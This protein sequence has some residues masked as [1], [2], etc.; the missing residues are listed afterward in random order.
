MKQPVPTIKDVAELTGLSVC[1]VSHAIHGTRHVKP[2]T[3][4]RVLAV[5]EQ[6]GYRP[7]RLARGL[8]T[9]RTNTVGCL[10]SHV[11]VPSVG[12]LVTGAE[13]V[14]VAHGYSP[15]LSCTHLQSSFELNAIRTLTDLRVDGLL[16]IGCSE[17]FVNKMAGFTEFPVVLVHCH[18]ASAT[19]DCV[20]IDDELAVKRATEHLLS[21]GHR[22]IGF[23]G[24]ASPR[25]MFTARRTGYSQALLSHGIPLQDRLICE[26]QPEPHEVRL[27]MTRLLSGSPRPTALV[28]AHAQLSYEVVRFLREKGIRVPDDVALVGMGSDP[29]NDLVDPPLTRISVPSLDLGRVAAELLVSRL[30]GR[31][32][33]SPQSV[34]LDAPLIVAGSCGSPMASSPSRAAG[35]NQ[36]GGAFFSSGVE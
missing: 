32:P 21:L 25:A 35:F 4:E 24:R 10:V 34:L 1:T 15:I 17:M 14:L 8:K 7:N 26:I 36:D 16:A 19:V 27:G 13:E 9:K 29:W 31:G 12:V 28:V 3:R 20:D 2:E 23:V 5:A 18:P 33:N 30:E 6:I 11:R 22:R